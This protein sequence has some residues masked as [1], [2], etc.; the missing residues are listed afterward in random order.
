[1]LIAMALSAV[2]LIAFL[3]LAVD[4]GRMFIAKNE[5]QTYCDSAA[6]AAALALDGTMTG[7]TKAQSAVTN[8]TNT[9][10]LDTTKVSSPT[11]TFATALAG[12]WAASPNPAT[13]YIYARVTATVPLKLYFLPIVVTQNDTECRFERNRGANCRNFVPSRS[14][15]IHCRQYE[16][17]RTE[18]WARRGKLL[19]YSVAAVQRHKEWLWAQHAGQVL[20]FATMHWRLG[21]FEDGCGF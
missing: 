12:P 2:A 19:R 5:T 15:A 18:L 16:H 3:G 1:M 6:L 11:L 9:W 14:I 7:I 17:D 8:S 4:M 10:N 20:R 13:G 21:G